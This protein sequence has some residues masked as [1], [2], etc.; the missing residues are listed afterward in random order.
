MRDELTKIYQEMQNKAAEAFNA[1]LVLGE[2]IAENP[3]LMLIGEAPGAQEEKEGKP[4]VGKAGK[5][6]TELLSIINIDRRDI[7][8]SNVVKLRPSKTSK[9]GNKI[10]RPPSNEEK[11]FFIPWIYREVAAIKPKAIVTLGN[12]ALSAFLGNAAKIGDFHGKWSSIKVNFN[13]DV[14][15]LRIFPLY[16]PAA[17][18]YNRALIDVYKEDL[19][20]LR[21]SI[22]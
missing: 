16:H 20:V 22:K 1:K 9:A 14:F 3:S 19:A 5:N 4:F 11:A 6:L 18:I 7:F 17:I 15:E 8:V 10:N 21:D 13:K 2:G 12:V